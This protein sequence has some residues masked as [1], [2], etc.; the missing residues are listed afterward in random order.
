G[1]RLIEIPDLNDFVMQATSETG[2][3]DY[4]F[5]NT[6]QGSELIKHFAE[7][8]PKEVMSTLNKIFQGLTRERLMKFRD[9]R[10]NL[11]W[12]L[13]KL[14]FRKEIFVPAATLLY[15]LGEAENENITN[16]A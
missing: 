8:T 11:V 9:G 14:C 10:R 6:N 5:V 1:Y 16:N 2:I 12:A 3:F 7:I 15:R 13:E 4:D